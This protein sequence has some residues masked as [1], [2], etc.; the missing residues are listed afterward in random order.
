MKIIAKRNISHNKV[1]YVAG[2]EIPQDV[3]GKGKNL[4]KQEFDHLEM[5]LADGAVEIVKESAP[6][7]ADASE[8]E[9]KKAK[10]AKA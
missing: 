9:A 5:L 3:L 7:E 8:G 4:L 1:K 2:Q 10:K 6:K